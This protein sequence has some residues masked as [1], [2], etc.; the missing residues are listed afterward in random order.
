MDV[1]FGDFIW[2]SH[3]E[4][5]NL[6]KH[7]VDFKSAAQAFSDP[8]RMIFLDKHHSILETRYFCLG[9]VNGLVLTVRFTYRKGKLR[10][11]GAGYWRKGKG[12][13]EEKTY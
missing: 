2:N 7:K 3:K 13:Y 11:F 10:I 8:E 12:L 9:C 5:A 4:R 1:V 6:L